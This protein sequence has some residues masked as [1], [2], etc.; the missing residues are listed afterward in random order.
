MKLLFC[1]LTFLAFDCIGQSD[2]KAIYMNDTL[3]DGTIVNKLDE[4][5]L[6]HGLYVM[7]NLLGETRARRV[8][9][10]GMESRGYEMGYYEHGCPVGKW[11][12]VQSNGFRHEGEY[13]CTIKPKEVKFRNKKGKDFQIGVWTTYSPDSNLRDYRRKYAYS[14]DGKYWT[15]FVYLEK[16][17]DTAFYLYTSRKYNNNENKHRYRNRNGNIEDKTFNQDGIL[18]K[19][20]YQSPKKRYIK[21][22]YDNGNIKST[23]IAWYSKGV[24]KLYKEVNYEY[25]GRVTKSETVKGQP[26]QTWHWCGTRSESFF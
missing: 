22:Y 16:K 13:H 15:D 7:P 25:N 19:E 8:D 17:D 18:T 26:K 14:F 20:K 3:Y 11:V 12:R 23:Q 1:L 5:G 9:F 6:Q 21:E 24:R 10:V 4:N 2:D